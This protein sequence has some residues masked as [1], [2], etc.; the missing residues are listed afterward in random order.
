MI[1]SL[2]TGSANAAAWFLDRHVEEGRAQAVCLV[3]E[4]GEKT[5]GELLELAERAGAAFSEAGVEPENRVVLILPD[6]TALAAAI[7]GAIRI[8]AVPV[9][10]STAFALDDYLYILADCRP[11]AVVVAPD[12]VA[13]VEAARE[14]LPLAPTAWVAGRDDAPDGFA[15]FDAAL[16]SEHGD[17]PLAPTTL[18]DMALFQ[19]T[20]GSTGAPKGV[21]HLHRGLLALPSTFGARLGLREDDRCFSAAKLS[22]GYGFGNSILFPFAAGASSV[23]FPGRADPFAVLEV[24]ERFEPTVFFAVPSLY[25]ALLA[26]PAVD[27]ARLASVRVCVSAGEPLSEAIF[28]RWR[29][30]FGLEIVNGLGSTECLHIFISAEAGRIRSAASGTVVP[31][32]DVELRGDDGAPVPD[33]EVGHVWVR[34]ECNGARYWSNEAETRETMVG[35]WTRTGDQMWRDDE[36]YWYFVGRSDDVLKIG[37]L[38]VSP[39]EVETCLL[40]HE[41]VAQCAVIGVPSED[42]V[43]TVTAYVCVAEGFEASTALRRE[44]REHARGLLAAYK[45]PGRIEFVDELPTTTTGKVARYK[46]RAGL[47]RSAL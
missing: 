15:S 20:S 29:E 38:K 13:T 47:S 31:G 42:G 3:E 40:R 33:G 1:G 16:A 4:E 26:V 18:D 11:K 45:V 5:Y 8:G 43:H 14:R 24:V 9:P 2:A 21:V 22:F 6:S 25:A 27:E 35:H 46:L 23:L 17:C 39:M 41:S 32:Y 7:W 34:S 19:Y 44:L 36:G 28:D 10:V 12:H 30:R 37:G